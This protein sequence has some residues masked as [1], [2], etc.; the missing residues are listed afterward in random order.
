MGVSQ[1]DNLSWTFASE[2]RKGQEG[3]QNF[4]S[5]VYKDLLVKPNFKGT[6]HIAAFQGVSLIIT[7]S[8]QA[9]HTEGIF[10]R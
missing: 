8:Q 9:A 4:Y 6:E 2:G 10:L 1:A 3:E 7:A 5:L